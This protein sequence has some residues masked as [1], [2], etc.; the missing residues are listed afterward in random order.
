MTTGDGKRFKGR[1]RE[2]TVDGRASG[3]TGN[4]E[5]RM[6]MGTMDD[7]VGDGKEEGTAAASETT[8]TRGR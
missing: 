4:G 2:G 3:T 7:R 8:G 1:R 6:T 5:W